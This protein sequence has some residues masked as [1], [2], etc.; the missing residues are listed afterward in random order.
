MRVK[1]GLAFQV[2]LL[3]ILFVSGCSLVDPLIYNNPESVY[4]YTP[5]S[6]TEIPLAGPFLF[7]IDPENTGILKSYH[8]PSYNDFSWQEIDAPDSWESQGIIEPQT[9]L[10]DDPYP[11]SGHAWYRKWINIPVEWEGKDLEII[12]GQVDDAYICYW[13]GEKVGERKEPACDN[14]IPIPRNLTRFNESNLLAIQVLDK[15]GEGGIVGGPLT[16]KPRFPWEKLELAINSKK[17][18]FLY[19]IYSPILLDL[20]FRNPFDAPLDIVL[21]IVIRDFDD[22]VVYKEQMNLRLNCHILTNLIVD[23]PSLLPGHYRCQFDVCG[24]FFILKTFRT[25]FAVIGPPVVFEDKKRSPFGLCGC[26]WISFPQEKYMTA[27]NRLLGLQKTSGAYWNRT[28]FLWNKVE[29]GKGEWDFTIADRMIENYD[30]FE[31]SVLGNLSNPPEWIKGRSPTN[32]EDVTAYTEYARIMA[33]RYRNLVN[34]W[35]VWHE[36][37]NPDYW[38]SQ[39]DAASYVHLLKETY[40]AIKQSDPEAMVIGMATRNTDLDFIKKALETGAGDYMDI[41]SVHLN[42]LRSPTNQTSDSDLNKLRELRKIMEH[43]GCNKPIWIT[44][45]G[46]QSLGSV[47]EKI[48]AEYLVKFYV[49]ILAEGIVD[50]IFWCNLM[51]DCESPYS[52]RGFFGL[53]HKDYTPKPSLA[54][55]HT[56]VTML[57]DFTEIRSLDLEEGVFGFE[58]EFKNLK[59]VRILW[60]E[61]EPQLVSIPPESRIVDLVGRTYKEIE[62]KMLIDKTPRYVIEEWE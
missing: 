50:R 60:T 15:W 45:C 44:E 24:K 19:D 21:K 23:I 7:M 26:D 14:T 43:H 10:S 46:W 47:S 59:K 35:E 17:G 31:I 1:I 25:S 2:F 55:Y 9:F 28:A 12:L 13:N 57:H 4:Q 40:S 51:D 8:M 32:K 54:A 22:L 41:V 61:R 20:N 6:Q 56:M 33:S 48:Q 11:Y 34:F 58:A 52:R 53:F 42:Q 27:K 36:P 37:N 39:P 38:S 3:I 62:G 5:M 30:L 18:D 29:P 49:M 16:L